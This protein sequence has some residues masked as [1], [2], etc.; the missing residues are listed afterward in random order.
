MKTVSISLATLFDDFQTLLPMSYKLLIF[1]GFT[2][3]LIQ[4]FIVWLNW[5]HVDYVKS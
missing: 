1:N 2:W 5:T 4:K 3:I